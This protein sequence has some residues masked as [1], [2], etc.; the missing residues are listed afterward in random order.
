MLTSA[1][2]QLLQNAF[3]FS[4]EGGHVSLKAYASAD[5][6]VLIEIADECGGLP[7]GTAAT[8]FRPAAGPDA[9]RRARS[10]L[11]IAERSIRANSGAIHVRDVPGTGCIFT[12]DLPR[13]A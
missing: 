10:G 8:L 3:N 13:R 5:N 11:S 2:A 9:A 1:V 7:P 12:I 4:R 6:R